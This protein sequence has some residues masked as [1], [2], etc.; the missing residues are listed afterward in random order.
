ML[1]GKR[2]DNMKVIWCKNVWC[3]HTY[4]PIL[5]GR[6][7][8]CVSAYVCMH[9]LWP[10]SS[11]Y[12]QDRQVWSEAFLQLSPHRLLQHCS[13]GIKE[14]LW[15]PGNS[16]QLHVEKHWPRAPT[17]GREK[18]EVQRISESGEGERKEEK[19]IFE[20]GKR[21]LSSSSLSQYIKSSL[22]LFDLGKLSPSEQRGP[23]QPSQQA[24]TVLFTVWL[25]ISGGLRR[26]D[27]A[28]KNVKNKQ[29]N[30]HIHKTVCISSTTI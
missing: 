20:E 3:W 26:A 9:A 21:R 6:E 27:T 11:V 22:Y 17:P 19:S 16:S 23:P 7:W 13:I 14:E 25:S 12:V 5:C 4:L 24:L 28:G 30:M 1:H 8:V 10:A 29:T 18:G 2:V 15:T